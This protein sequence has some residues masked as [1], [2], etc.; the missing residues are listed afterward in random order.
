MSHKFIYGLA[1]AAGLAIGVVGGSGS[2]VAQSGPICSTFGVDSASLDSWGPCPNAPNIVVTTSNVGS[3][4][5]PGD[6]YLHLRDTAGASAA[7]S[8]NQKYLGNWIEKMGGCGQF[9]FDFKVIK[10]GTPPG[11]IT[12]SFT[13]WSGLTA[14]A[15]FVA[16]FTVTSADAWRHICAPVNLSDSPP[17]NGDGHWVV[18]GGT[19]NA[20]ASAVTM[21]QLPIDWTSDPSEEAGYDNLCMNPKTCD[22][23][24]PVI[25]GCLKDSKV[26]VKCNPDGTYTLTLSGGSFTGNTIT[27][28][29]QTTGVTVTPP[30]QPWA[31]TTSWIITGATAG[32]TVT[33]VANATKT[34]GGSQ[35]GTDQCCSGE[36]KIVMPECQKGIVVVE[37]KVKNYTRASIAAINALVFPIG[38]SC[39]LPSTLST[40][41]SLHNGDTHT[42]NNIPYTS[43]CN[44]TESMSTLPPVPT[45][46]CPQGSTATWALPVVVP[47]S[48]G[49]NISAPITAFTVINELNCSDKTPV[50]DVGIAK[51]GGT[52]PACLVPA[53]Y[54]GVTVTN[55]GGAWPGT[56]NIV[57]T[58]TVPA[59]MTFGPITAPGWSCP[60]GII[61]AGTTFTCTYTGPTPT[62]GQ[63]LP[64][65]GIPATPTV[66]PPFP[67]YT[68]SA[69]V[70][71]TTSSGYVDSNP[72]NDNA[73]TP[74]VTKPSSC[75]C[76]SPQVMNADGI[77][78][79]PPP[80]PICPPPLVPGPIKGQCICPLGTVMVDGQCVKRTTCDPPMVPGPVAGQCICGPG[81]TLRGKKCVKT[82]V[83]RPPLVPNAAGTDC[84]CRGGLVLR[85]GKCVEPVVCRA[86][87]KLNKAGTG[88]NCPEGTTKRGNS[89][90]E[91]EKPRIRTEG[92][93][94]G[95]DVIRGIGGGG[96]SGRNGGGGGGGPAKGGG[97]PGKP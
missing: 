97:S 51:T 5:G 33:L 14:R 13:I 61:P 56:N 78:V 8:T 75:D 59:N 81:Y 6:Y 96:G 79:N 38:L 66:G 47:P 35:P 74:P 90:V 60:T 46:A 70:A 3:I 50:I 77:C 84:V 82:L 19:W 43:L 31:T 40:S 53:Y 25:D 39:G 29:S 2:A 58:D 76:P 83:C 21:M 23:P 27:L 9:C 91:K 87:A 7:C 30:Q 22:P 89:C 64:T 62:A 88:C 48:P 11:P 49:V 16:N 68:N 12:P 32:Q 92:V 85:G 34:G 18:T 67:P 20:I 73:T 86:P 10:S 57:V 93:I 28:T 80:P 44:V 45:D 69:S 54:F 17:A 42:E 63:V 1:L 52:T 15:T 37:K 36:I 65:I 95:I 72:A 24:P 4:G 55:L 41:F 94:R 71:I 26:T